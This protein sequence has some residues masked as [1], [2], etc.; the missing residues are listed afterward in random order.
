MSCQKNKQKRKYLYQAPPQP[1]GGLETVPLWT[2]HIDHKGLL[3][4]SSS[5][6]EH[7]HV[8]LD[9]FLGLSKSIQLKVLRRWIRPRLWKTRFE[10]L[11]LSQV[12]VYDR[13]SAFINIEITNWAIE[14]GITSVPQTD[15]SPWAN[16]IVEIQ[17][18]NLI[19][20][21]CHFLSK[22]GSNWA[23]FR[24]KIAFAHNTSANTATGSTPYEFVFA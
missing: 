14:L 17:N 12:L 2:S 1:W 24:P 4:P 11:E 18:K 6:F 7:C 5:D 8:I 13:R 22:N 21:F 16:L 15:H 10:L 23:L 3:Y 20:F 9:F 19:Q